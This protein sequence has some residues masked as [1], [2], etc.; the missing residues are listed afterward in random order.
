MLI[1]PVVADVPKVV[2]ARTYVIAGSDTVIPL[3]AEKK[4]ED[5][6]GNKC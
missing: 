4:F 2:R 3:R 1:R 5:I 6:N